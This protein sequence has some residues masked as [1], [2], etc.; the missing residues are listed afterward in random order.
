M[1]SSYT[2]QLAA[3]R[4]ANAALRQKEVENEGRLAGISGLI[5]KAYHEQ[6]DLGMERAMGRLEVENEV[7]REALGLDR[8]PGG[9]VD[10]P[11]G[12]APGV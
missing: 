4:N 10:L 2:N 5:R 3:E 1:H 12:P 11:E 8:E 6:T 7:L 9:L